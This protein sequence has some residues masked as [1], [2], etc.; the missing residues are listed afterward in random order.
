LD[1]DP[2]FINKKV[3]K[4]DIL[5]HIVDIPED[6]AEAV[7]LA[8]GRLAEEFPPIN[9]KTVGTFHYYNDGPGKE[10]V[11]GYLVGGFE[12]HALHHAIN[13]VLHDLLPDYPPNVIFQPTIGQGREGFLP[14]YKM[15]NQPIEFGIDRFHLVEEGVVIE[16]ELEGGEDA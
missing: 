10:R 14:Q 12:I 4:P 6:H 2:R 11:Y 5:L 9:A 13:K 7:G 8:L 16:Y 15:S 1:D 3:D